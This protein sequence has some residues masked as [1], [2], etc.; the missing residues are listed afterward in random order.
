MGSKGAGKQLGPEIAAQRLCIGLTDLPD[1]GRPWTGRDVADAQRSRPEWLKCARTARAEEDRLHKARRDAVR[2]R[3]IGFEYPAITVAATDFARDFARANLLAF[4][5]DVLDVAAADT[6]VVDCGFDVSTHARQVDET[7]RERAKRGVSLSGRDKQW[8]RDHGLDREPGTLGDLLDAPT[9]NTRATYVSGAGLAAE[10]FDDAWYDRWALE[11]LGH[12]HVIADLVMRGDVATLETIAGVPLPDVDFDEIRQPFD[13][14][15]RD[16]L[17]LAC[18]ALHEWTE[19]DCPVLDP[20]ALVD[21]DA[22]I[23]ALS[24]MLLAARR[25]W[26][27]TELLAAAIAGLDVEAAADG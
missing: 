8:C 17:A 15:A 13:G 7:N 9:G 23:S 18:Q 14:V 21:M 4:L 22:P 19:I 11:G 6:Y 27:Q 12:A 20:D 24:G 3:R 16:V 10:T 26:G 1:L 5:R 25:P 2:A